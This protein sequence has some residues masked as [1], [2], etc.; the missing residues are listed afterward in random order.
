[1]GKED[2]TA[3]SAGSCRKVTEMAEQD[4]SKQCMTRGQKITYGHENCPAIEVAT[5]RV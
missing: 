1:M 5:Q 3:V 4:S 2:L